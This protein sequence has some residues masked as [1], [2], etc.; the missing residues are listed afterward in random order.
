MCLFYN[1]FPFYLSFSFPLHRNVIH[2]IYKTLSISQFYFDT[3]CTIR[4]LSATTYTLHN[5]NASNLATDI[6]ECLPGGNNDCDP[7]RAVCQDLTPFY[8]CLC[9]NGY[10]GNGTHCTGTNKLMDKVVIII[11][12]VFFIR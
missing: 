3:V 2:F 10:Q 12:I 4:Y 8:S 7:D 9:A 1:S 6:D 5:E 11:L